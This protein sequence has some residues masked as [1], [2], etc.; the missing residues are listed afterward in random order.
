LDEFKSA[1]KKAA[2][3][4]DCDLLIRG[5]LKNNHL[6]TISFKAAKQETQCD[7]YDL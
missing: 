4:P 7:D 2:Y 3:Y 1:I 6:K 5:Y